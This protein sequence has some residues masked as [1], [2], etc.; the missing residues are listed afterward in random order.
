LCFVRRL[1]DAKA[2]GSDKFVI[3]A[4]A[5]A[6]VDFDAENR[7]AHERMS[8]FPTII[9]FPENIRGALMSRTASAEFSSF[10]FFIFPGL[11]LL[12]ILHES[13]LRSVNG[14]FIATEF[15]LPRTWRLP[16]TGLSFA[17]FST[18]DFA[19]AHLLESPNGVCGVHALSLG[20]TSDLAV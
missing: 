18:C 12:M 9:S 4:T 1:E 14:F 11:A 19:I 2:I 20:W 3:A 15:S 13:E 5:H 10:A 16:F 7:H 17:C 8:Q 6:L